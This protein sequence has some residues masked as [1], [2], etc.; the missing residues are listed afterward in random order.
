[1]GSSLSQ[2]QLKHRDELLSLVKKANYLQKANGT[3]VYPLSKKYLDDFLS[4]VQQHCPAYP[5]EGTLK[6]S[7]W[8]RMGKWMHEPPR[9]PPQIICSWHAVMAALNILF[10]DDSIQSS[11]DP[12]S[13]ELC[14]VAASAPP[15]YSTPPLDSSPNPSSP[16][17][18]SAMATDPPVRNAF[19]SALAEGKLSVD[20]LSCFPMILQT[21]AAGGNPVPHYTPLEWTLLKELKTAASKYGIDSPYTRQLLANISTHHLVLA[22]EWKAIASMLLSPASLAT[23]HNEFCLSINAAAAAGLPAG[24]TLDHLLCQ[25]TVQ[26]PAQEITMGAGGYPIMREAALNAFKRLPNTSQPTHSFTSI[27]QGPSEPYTSFIDHLTDAISRQVDNIAAQSEL[28]M[29]LAVANANVD[30]QKILKPLQVLPTQNLADLFALLG[31]P[32]ILKTDNGP[33]YTSSAFSEF[34]HHWSINHKFG[35]PF[36][37]QGQ[38][39]VERAN[40]T[41]KQALDRYTGSKGIS[42]PNLPTLQNLL[43]VCLYTLN[44]LNLTGNPPSSAV[45]R[46]FTK[47]SLPTARP[48]VYYRQLPDPAWKGPAELI[49]WGRDINQI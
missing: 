49:T 12:P 33:A 1:M 7:S 32:K 44:F 47:P 10:P 43:N 24:V 20:D 41:L 38:A 14:P 35:I 37:S 48:L 28:L 46:H 23:W 34:C 11:S 36:N 42:P 9:A 2:V 27:L 19:Q 40:Q 3:N 17:P 4:Y 22:S 45:S 31:C 29:R 18:P 16:L 6:R 13:A 30:C 21:P 25:G 5:A 26:N 39:I 15:P 8:E